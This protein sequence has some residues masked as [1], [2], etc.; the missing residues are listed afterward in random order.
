MS[1]KMVGIN[2][3]GEMKP[4]FDD[5]LS[6]EALQ[7]LEQ[8]E[9]RFGDR[10]RELLH[11]RDQQQERINRGEL[12]SFLPETES[13]RQSEWKV[14]PI[15]QALQDRRVEITG[16]VDRKMVIN[17]LN[18]GAKCF[19]ACFEDATSPT[20]TNLIEGQINLRD[21]V[22]H[23]IDFETN[24]KRYELK[25][26]HAVLIVRPRGLHL[27]EKHIEL[28][29]KPLSASLVD[30]GL[31]FF[32]N[33]TSLTSQNQGPYFYLPKL[34]SHLEARLWNDVFVYAQKYVGIPQG[35]IKATVLIET[36]TAAF[37]MDEILYE[38]KEHSAG[39]NCGRW[40]Y[41][42][43]Y[44]KKLREQEDVILPDRSS[45]TMTSPFMRA[46]SLLTIKTCHRRGAPAIG[47]MAAQIP[48]KNDP[49]KNEEAFNK[50]RADKEREAR[51]GHD[52]TWVAHPGLV[53]VAMDVFNQEMEKPNQIDLKKLEDLEVS[54][55]ELLAVP[56]GRITEE[57]VRLNINVGIQ[58]ISSWLSGQGAAPIH[59]LMEDVATA[60]ISRAQL[61]QW[62]RHPKGV[63]DDGRDITIG[64]YE[65]LKQEELTKLK[66]QLGD[67]H[68]NQR[69]FHEAVQLFDDLIQNDTFTDFLTIPGYRIL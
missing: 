21:A 53:P 57:G 4:G 12:P 56:E 33:A 63:L 65:Q 22:H 54:A 37:E 38:L 49:V 30:F 27:E 59:N 6:P 40:D 55:E 16:P 50:V 14:S 69:R 68:Y 51:D 43:S 8:L 46:Y 32:H 11:N 31:F 20:W 23:T 64:L 28:D 44:I 52:G 18:S 58:Y 60:E 26:D 17:A 39:L 48:V 19:M 3:T 41:I 47:G 7:F 9:R 10:Q 29:G 13:I 45:V 35:T 67:E 25:K 66:S 15:P 24:G 5:I 61:W 34:E 42:F 1:T 62:I 2:V 36:I